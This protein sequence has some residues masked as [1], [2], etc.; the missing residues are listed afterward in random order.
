MIAPD[1]KTIRGREM[2]DIKGLLRENAKLEFG[3]GAYGP[4]LILNFD[5]EGNINVVNSDGDFNIKCQ[6]FKIKPIT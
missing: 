5:S 1:I 3:K 2:K 4:A 6:R